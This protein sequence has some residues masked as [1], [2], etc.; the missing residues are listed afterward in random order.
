MKDIKK[1]NLILFLF[2]IQITIVSCRKDKTNLTNFECFTFG[3]IGNKWTYERIVYSDL[4]GDTLYIDT[5]QAEIIEKN[6]NICKFNNS[7]SYKFNNYYVGSYFAGLKNNSPLEIDLIVKCNSKKGDVHSSNFIGYKYDPKYNIVSV[8]FPFIYKGKT[9]NCCHVL[10][11]D[12]ET[13]INYYV[14]HQ[15]GIVKT[16]GGAPI[17]KSPTYKLIDTNF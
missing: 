10:F 15:Y 11:Y 8:D 1:C 9:I 2:L 6:N 7:P 4:M 14:N 16:S 3:E 12:G 17:Y 13:T 5:I